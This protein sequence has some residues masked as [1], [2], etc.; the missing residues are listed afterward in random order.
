MPDT[1][2]RDLLVERVDQQ[3]EMIKDLQAEKRQHAQRLDS[4]REMIRRLDLAVYGDRDVNLLSLAAQIAAVVA[5]NALVLQRL[6]NISLRFTV[7]GQRFTIIMYL[8]GVLIGALL[9]GALGFL[10]W[11]LA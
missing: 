11:R 4:H 10:L 7:I 5:Q 6:E 1:E 3:G 2:P 9:F 8:L